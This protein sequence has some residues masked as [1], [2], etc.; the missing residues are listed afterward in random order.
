MDPVP[1]AL[2]PSERDINR[3]PDRHAMARR[4]GRDHRQF[5]RILIRIVEESARALAVEIVT[6]H[7]AIA[8]RKA[9]LNAKLERLVPIIHTR[10]ESLRERAILRI[11]FQQGDRKSTRLN[12]S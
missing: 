11:R 6:P 4:R 7:Q 5:V 9:P 12:S 10:Q 8:L 3:S 1:E 2:P